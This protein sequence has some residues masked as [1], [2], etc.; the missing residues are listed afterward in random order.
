MKRPLCIVLCKD[1]PYDLINIL[2]PI[3]SF[4][5]HEIV[6]KLNLH[7]FLVPVTQQ[8]NSQKYFDFWRLT[9]ILIIHICEVLLV[10]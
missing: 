1:C 7:I 9:G 4:C 6:V 8:E 3:Q 2:D 5:K 10:L